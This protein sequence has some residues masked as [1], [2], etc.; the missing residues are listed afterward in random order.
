V[1]LL[2]NGFPPEHRKPGCCI[3][4]ALKHRDQWQNKPLRASVWSPLF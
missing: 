2:T 4:D 1:H 3:V